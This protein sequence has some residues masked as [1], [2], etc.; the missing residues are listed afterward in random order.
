MSNIL[1]ENGYFVQALARLQRNGGESLKEFP[2]FIKL[3]IRNRA[4][5][6]WVDPPTQNRYSQPDFETFVVTPVLEGIGSTVQQ[7]KDLCRHDDDAQKAIDSVL[8]RPAGNPTGNNQH[9]KET[10]IVDIVNDSS[11]ERPTGNSRAAGLRRLKKDRPDLY[12][13][14][15]KTKSVNQAMVEAGF[16]KKTMTV[17]TDVEGLAKHIKKHFSTDQIEQLMKYVNFGGNIVNESCE[18]NLELIQKINDLLQQIKSPQQRQAITRRIDDDL[19]YQCAKLKIE[20]S[21]Q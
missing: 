17:P 1:V 2:D 4:W 8:Q 19:Q 18:L 5:E 13:E 10:G 15:G 6:G 9:T 11:V 7:V 12:D 16:R 21:S 3:V 14:V 20:I